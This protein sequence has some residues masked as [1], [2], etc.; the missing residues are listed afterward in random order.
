[1]KDQTRRLTTPVP[2]PVL[3]TLVVVLSIVATIG[4]ARLFDARQSRPVAP[5]PPAVAEAPAE[6]G[7][8]APTSSGWLDTVGYERLD[9]LA[10]T[11]SSWE[12]TVGYAPLTPVAVVAPVPAA[13]APAN[14]FAPTSS[15]WEQTVGYEGLAPV[16]RLAPTSS[17][18]LFENPICQESGEPAAPSG[19]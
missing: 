6:A 17:S 18:Y 4:A 1:M 10:P 5:A 13:I 19:R 7:R 15:A 3:F 16:N 12:Q 9:R 11:S 2:Y 8:F 14:R